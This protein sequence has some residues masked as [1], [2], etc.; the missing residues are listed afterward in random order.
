MTRT[1]EPSRRRRAGPAAHY[2]APGIGAKIG[3]QHIVGELA[4][5][6]HFGGDRQVVLKSEER[7]NDVVAKAALTVRRPRADHSVFGFGSKRLHEGYVV[8]R[9]LLLQLVENRKLRGQGGID[10]TPDMVEIVAEQVIIRTV[11]ESLGIERQFLM[12]QTT[13]L[14]TLTS[15]PGKAEG[16]VKRMKHRE[17]Q[18]NAHERQARRRQPFAETAHDGFKRFVA[19]RGSHEPVSDLVQED[20]GNIVVDR[21]HAISSSSRQR[22]PPAPTAEQRSLARGSTEVGTRR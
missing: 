21:A 3:G 10:P 19:E 12:T 9:S 18:M 7:R 6:G 16:V 4:E 5:H 22:S 14:D 15:P 8:G 1:A 13:H 20:F 2:A 11:Q 17:R